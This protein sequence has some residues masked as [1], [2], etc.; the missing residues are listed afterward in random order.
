[1]RKSGRDCWPKLPVAG[2][3]PLRRELGGPGRRAMFDGCGRAATDAYAVDRRARRR[4]AGVV[5][6]AVAVAGVIS[7][8]LITQTMSDTPTFVSTG[9][10]P[11][12]ERV[13]ALVAEAYERFRDNSDGELSH[14]LSLARALDPDRFGICVANTTGGVVAAGDA[15]IGVHD[16]ER[17]QA[18]RVRARC[19]TAH[20]RRGRA[21]ACRSSTPRAC[22]ST[23]VIAIERSPDGRT[24]PMVNPGAI[25]TTEHGPGRL[26]RG[27]V[28]SSC[29]TGCRASP[30]ARWRWTTRS[31]ASAIGDATIAIGR[32]PTCCAAAAALACRSR[33]DGRPL[34][35]AELRS[36]S[37]ARDLA[38]MGAT[39]AERRRQPA[40]GRACRVEPGQLHGAHWS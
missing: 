21:P 7:R 3:G 37:T 20:G 10:L 29:S 24:N 36:A 19:A 23:R 5:A 14:G 30:A 25:A 4:N 6:F 9:M 39:L 17:R 18:V 34:H 33:R 13:T 15:D 2:R 11:P 35:A 1:M 38:V 31:Y 32:S 12:G 40:H 8:V 22:R 26:A 27:A 16:H 28:G